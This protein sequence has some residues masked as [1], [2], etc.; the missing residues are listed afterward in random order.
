MF[1]CFSR[2]EEAESKPRESHVMKRKGRKGAKFKRE[3]IKGEL[4]KLRDY[5]S[6]VI[7]TYI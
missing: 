6:L 5:H 2:N 1:V 7:C 3:I 4:D